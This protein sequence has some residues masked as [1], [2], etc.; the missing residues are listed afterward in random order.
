MVCIG[1]PTDKEQQGSNANEDDVE[2]QSAREDIKHLQC[3]LTDTFTC[4]RTMMVELHYAHV[5]IVAVRSTWRSP[6]LTLPALT[7]PLWTGCVAERVILRR[8]ENEPWVGAGGVQ[9]RNTS[10]GCGHDANHKNSRVQPPSYILKPKIRQPADQGKRD[11]H[12]WPV[13]TDEELY[14]EARRARATNQVHAPVC[15][16]AFT[17][18]LGIEC[19]RMISKLHI[20]MLA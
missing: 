2:A 13:G 17:R 16:T 15:R 3:A 18:L 1:S 6:N 5:A 8:F 7:I 20:R 10:Y 4:P 19:S 12:A 14:R 11:A 9:V